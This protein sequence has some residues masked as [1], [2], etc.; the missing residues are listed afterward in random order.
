MVNVKKMS[1][2]SCTN[3]IIKRGMFNCHSFVKFYFLQFFKA[4][5]QFVCH[6]YR[7][8]ETVIMFL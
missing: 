5:K 1:E 8:I 7:R 4:G 6:E 3:K 2:A